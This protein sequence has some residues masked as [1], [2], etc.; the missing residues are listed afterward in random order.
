MDERGSFRSYSPKSGT[1]NANTRGL[2]DGS[3]SIQA[4]RFVDEALG[5]R[6]AL[7]TLEGFK[8]DPGMAEV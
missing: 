8:V 1:W 7:A 6:V 4:V 3:S 5:R 2:F